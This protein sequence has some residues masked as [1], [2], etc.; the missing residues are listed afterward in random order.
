MFRS[1]W[2]NF[3]SGCE[4]SKNL[5]TW[6]SLR[7]VDGFTKCFFD[8][9]NELNVQNATNNYSFTEA[10]YV[11]CYWTERGCFDLE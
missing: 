11:V 9:K 6:F 5:L 7:E 4:N 3:F 2:D 1:V 8:W 10:S